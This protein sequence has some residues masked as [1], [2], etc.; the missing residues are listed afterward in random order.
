MWSL[1]LLLRRKKLKRLK[2]KRMLKI[3]KRKR[4]P[5]RKRRARK[6]AMMTKRSLL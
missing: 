2:K 6:V 3:R 1:H 5:Q 4:L